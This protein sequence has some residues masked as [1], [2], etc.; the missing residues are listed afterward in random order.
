[1][2]GALAPF[3][4]PLFRRVWA[5]STAS[6]LGG[7][8]QTVGAAWLMLAL[9]GSP[10]MVALVQASV[11]LPV[12]LFSLAAG[13]VA[14]NLDRRR[15]MLAAQVFL[16]AIAAML[17]LVTWLGHVNAW[18]LLALT[19]LIGCGSAFHNPAWQAAVGDMVPR[20][21]LPGAVAL[22][23]MGFNIARSVG[24]ALG[25]AVVASLGAAAAF[26]INAL[27]YVGLIAVLARWR[28]PV[29]EN[30]LPRESLGGAIRAG[31]RYVAMSPA[32]LTVFAR[33][34]VFGA[35]ASAVMALM[36]LVA[37]RRLGGG[38]VTYGLLLG[39]FGVGAVVGAF[40][41]ARLRAALSTE[42]LVRTGTIA[43]AAAAAATGASTQL[44]A[45]LV[46]LLAA[47]AAWV[48]TLSTFNVAVQLSTSRWVVARA[49]SL[50]HMAAF[51]GIAAGSALWGWVAASRD[52][53]VALYAAALV[54]VACAAMGLRWRLDQIEARNLD[55]LRRW[56]APE[57]AVPVDARTGPVVVTIEY[58]IR[59]EDASE[60]IETMAERRRIRRRDGA[61][62]WALLR[63]LADPMVWIE[64]YMLPTWLDYIRHNNRMTHDD[65]SVP[66]RL[67]ELHQGPEP[68]RVHRMI[69]RPTRIVPD[70]QRREV[71]EPLT[72]PNRGA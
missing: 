45:T 66:A 72:D 50:Y 24:P 63:D 37:S 59:E 7:M 17:A 16:L 46:A 68:P 34:A 67:R 4:Y 54:L 15:V 47:G 20:D 61:R 56:D 70:P 52:I 69:E 5:A 64:R 36:P 11:A 13:A 53:D 28:T 30:P 23:S 33:S 35:G 2:K 62:H 31:L 14:D 55:P 42:S 27:S 41:A 1:V 39:A 48:L 58:R 21:E 18:L 6:N 3:S 22:N 32:I 12:V 10:R 40:S 9:T 8:I 38:P 25:G 49:L 57:T 51:G 60:F 65:A 44:A 29:V 71:Q 43:F 26:A 19:F